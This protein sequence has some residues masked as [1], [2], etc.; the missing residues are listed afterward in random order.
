MQPALFVGGLVA[1]VIGTVFAAPGAIRAGGRLSRRLPFAPRVALRDLARYQARGAAALGA[2]TLGLAVSVG[3]VAVAAAAEPAPEDGD[4]SGRELLI[5]VGDLETAPPSDLTAAEI[6]ALD[7]RA[8][9]V[10][11]AIGEDVDSA[12]LDVAVSTRPTPDASPAEPVAIGVSRGP[13][14]IEGRGRPFVATREILDLYGIEPQSIEPGVEL[15]TSR[16][17]PFL[18]LDFTA[19]PEPDAPPT[20]MQHVD[21]PKYGSAP[22]ALVTEAAMAEHGWVPARA[23][24]I[25]ESPS[26]LTRDQVQAARQ[27]AAD[28]GLA[29]EA[30][31]T[32]DEL[33]ALRTGAT[34][35]GGL[36]AVAIV[37]ISVGLIRNEARRDVRTL[38]ATGAKARTRRALTATTAAG[39]AVPGVL[40][41]VTGA[42]LAL[43]ASYHADLGRLLPIPLEQLLPL[44]I[45]TPLAAAAV[46]WLLAG[47]EPRSFARQELE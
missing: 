4:L 22:N 15:L 9:D 41:G 46:G 45:G 32:N 38:T 27:A 28:V 37:A 2:I 33:A 26:P 13:E 14:R 5:L 12:P 44:A 43:V 25:V 36:L 21:L 1:V 40:L 34:L 7:R 47:R 31:S 20:E 30:R 39:L 42:Y 24:W 11:A 19:R 3:I 23:G 18:L 10:V 6:A 29:V 17:E 35:V 8:A 16:N